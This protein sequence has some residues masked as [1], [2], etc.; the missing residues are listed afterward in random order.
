VKPGGHV[1]LATFSLQGPE[2]CSGLPVVRYDATSVSAELGNDFELLEERF[3][4][5]V[6]PA[7]ITQKFIWC[8]L[9]RT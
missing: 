3:E 8:R 5:H 2:K 9:R 4:D 6:T 1:I 7:G